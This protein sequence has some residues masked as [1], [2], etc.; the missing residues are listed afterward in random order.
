MA[1]PRQLQEGLRRR[2]KDA[3]PRPIVEQLPAISVKELKIPSL[4]NPKTYILPNISL[5]IPQLTNVRVCNVF[6]EF[7]HKPLHRGDEPLIQTFNLKHHRA[8]FGIR[9]A[10]VCTCGKGIYKLYY[11][12]RRI[13]CRHCHNAVYASQAIS[14]QSRPVLQET[15]TKY[16]L[17]NTTKLGESTRKRLEQRLGHKTSCPKARWEQE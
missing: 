15:R 4:N 6:V 5:R 3:P 12:N 13:A 1:M 9:A 8:G 2:P 7:H 10:F 16:F 11:L 17:N 14:R